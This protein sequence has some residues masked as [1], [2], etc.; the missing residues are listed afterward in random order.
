MVEARAY[1]RGLLNDLSAYFA[2]QTAAT[3]GEGFTDGGFFEKSPSIESVNEDYSIDHDVRRFRS[4]QGALAIEAKTRE[5]NKR[6]NSY[7]ELALLAVEEFLAINRYTQ[8]D[9]DNI[10]PALRLSDEL[11]ISKWSSH[12][13]LAESGLK[14][15]PVYNGLV[16]RGAK[17]GSWAAEYQVGAVVTEKGF[18]S[19]SSVTKMSLSFPL[20]FE[21]QSKTGRNIGSCSAMQSESARESE[22]LFAPDTRFEVTGRFERNGAT[23]IQMRE[24]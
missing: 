15:L 7:G 17:Q 18:T 8:Y 6:L 2:L 5:Y 19:S 1:L 20:Q 16:Y 14:K 4:N 10:N 9:Y 23:V 21:I 12:I 13:R 11:N 24:L 3:T 22:I